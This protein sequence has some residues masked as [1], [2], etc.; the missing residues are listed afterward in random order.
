M[1]FLSKLK[2]LFG[3]PEFHI[4][5]EHRT[6]EAFTSNGITYYCFDDN[7]QLP[8]DRFFSAMQF[9]E[10]LKMKCSRDYLLAHVQAVDDAINNKNIQLTKIIQANNNLRE[11]LEFIFEPD[12]AY[13]LASVVFFDHTENPYEYDFKYGLEKIE[14]WKKEKVSD[15]FLQMPIRKL[16]G[17]GGL[18]EADLEH[19]TQVGRQMTKA[20]IS[21]LSSTLS[22]ESKKKEFYK[23]LESLKAKI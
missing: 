15:F 20:H 18:S 4:K 16:I 17:L 22:E 2:S 6:V 11:R 21:A 1:N 7:L 5:P 19:Y 3:K 9:Y 12:I 23:T 13:K 10:E 14:R 8:H